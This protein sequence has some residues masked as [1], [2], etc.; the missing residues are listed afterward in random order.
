VAD[1]SAGRLQIE[2]PP[3]KLTPYERLQRQYEE[4][5]SEH[6]NLMWQFDELK[7]KMPKAEEVN[8]EPPF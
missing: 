5:K 4:L 3:K 2:T 8:G 6:W 1:Y 7:M